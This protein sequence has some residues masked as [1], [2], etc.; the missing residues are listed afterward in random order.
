MTDKTFIV[1]LT[2]EMHRAVRIEAAKRGMTMMQLVNYA[3][4]YYLAGVIG[5]EKDPAK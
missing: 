3:L 5:S 1:R 2:P 4:S